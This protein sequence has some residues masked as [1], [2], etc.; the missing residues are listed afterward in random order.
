MLES[1]DCHISA[2]SL[3]VAYPGAV[4]PLDPAPHRQQAFERV[5]RWLL[6]VRPNLL[7]VYF[8][9][10]LQLRLLAYV[11]LDGL[12]SPVRA[13]HLL[14]ASRGCHHL[15]HATGDMA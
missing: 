3:P 9:N 12:I 8:E 4:Q 5:A 7:S 6:R 14:Q 13:G 11:F 10:V 2:T 1:H 15:Q